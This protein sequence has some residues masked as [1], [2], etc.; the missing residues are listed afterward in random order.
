MAETTK[1]FVP[2]HT[3][4]REW[5]ARFNVPTQE[6]LQALID[7]TQSEA[8][9][10]KFRYA[11]IG[12]VEVGDR[13]YQ[14]DFNI[15]HVHCALVYNNR[16]SK[17]S[18][19]K[20]LGIKQGHGYYLVPRRQELPYSGWKEHH[21]KVKTKE[22]EKSLVLFEYGDIPQDKPNTT[23]QVTKRSD[24]EK[25]R[26]LDEIIMEMRADIEAGNDEEAF[27]K[28]PRNY[29][30][31]GEKIKALISQR[32]Q[33]FK[34]N[35]DPHIWIRGHPGSGKSAILQ[36]VYP[37]YYNKNLDNRFYDLYN[38]AVHTHMLLQDVDHNTVEKLGVQFLKTICDEAG[39]PVDQK[40]KTPQLARTTVLVSS[41][42]G[43]AEV[44]PEDLKGRNENLKALSRRF[45]QVNVHE[46]LRILGVKLLSPYELKQLKKAANM[47][48]RK[49]FMAY[50]YARDCPTGEPLKSAA[51]YQQKIKDAYY[52][53]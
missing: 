11:L 16:V 41:N 42:F 15:R 12:G 34:S 6:D 8:L 3:L 37:D 18:I 50:D 44:L 32:R 48:P 2:F 38:P 10:G 35:G 43:L 5:D 23:A 20:N 9:D 30:T 24:Q 53:K 1:N 40:Y 52:G 22:D 46:F 14:N 13:P 51:E 31:Y 29:L 21:T 19:L 27:R 7:L 33:F 47:D 28:F 39:F 4:A 17:S 49:I 36:V 25:K 26:K 45:W